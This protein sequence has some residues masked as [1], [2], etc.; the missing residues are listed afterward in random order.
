MGPAYVSDTI[1]VYKRTFGQAGVVEVMVG[2][3]DTMEAPASNHSRGKCI[4]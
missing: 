3:W 1:L 4:I 2:E